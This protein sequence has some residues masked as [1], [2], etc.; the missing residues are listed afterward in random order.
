MSTLS[1]A[2]CSEIRLIAPD[3]LEC[4]P[5]RVRVGGCVWRALKCVLGRA[6]GRVPVETFARAVWGKVPEKNETLRSVI[7]R[8]NN[9]L[10]GLGHPKRLVLDGEAVEWM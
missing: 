5:N 4:G 3:A 7:W 9:T 2:S 8:V 6:S 10:K 1:P